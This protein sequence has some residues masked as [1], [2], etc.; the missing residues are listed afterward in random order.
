[1][2]RWL[3]VAPF[4]LAFAP[5]L[6]WLYGHWTASVYRNGHGIFVPFVMAYLVYEHLKLDPDPEPRSSAWGFAFLVPALA[7]LVLDAPIKTELLAAFAL[8][9]SLPGISLLLLG[10]R[11]TRALALPL[12]L[13]LFMLPIPA[14][15][16]VPVHLVLQKITAVGTAALL[17]LVGVTLARE[18]LILHV[19]NVTVRVAENCSASASRTHRS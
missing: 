6:L 13:G 19:P 3:W 9:L 17:Q 2:R 11:R 7:L 16:L 4:A 5:T 15:V 10:V 1:M 14:G 8:V 12:A 18:G